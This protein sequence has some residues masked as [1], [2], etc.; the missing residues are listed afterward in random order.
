EAL[1]FEAGQTGS[2][3]QGLV[4][5]H[6]AEPLGTTQVLALDV[7][8]QHGPDGTIAHRPRTTGPADPT[9]RTRTGD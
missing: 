4:V 7:P 5:G 8:V 2:A 1:D 6:A 3:K 9:W